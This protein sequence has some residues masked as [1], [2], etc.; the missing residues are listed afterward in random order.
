[1]K[2]IAEFRFSYFFEDRIVFLG[3]N[4]VK[5]QATSLGNSVDEIDID[6]NDLLEK[7]RADTTGQFAQIFSAF[8]ERLR[9]IIRFRLDYRLAPR[10]SDSDVIQECYVRA[11]D[12]LERFLKNPEFPFFVWLRMQA[13]QQVADLHRKHL[14]AEKRDAR[15]E[16]NLNARNQ[17][18]NQTSVQLAAHL[19]AQ[20]TSPSRL[21]QRSEEIVAL[22]NSLNEMNDLDR[23]V[24]ALRHFEELSSNETAQV[25]GIQPAAASKRYVRA[26]KRLQEIMANHGFSG[27]R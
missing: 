13:N 14:Q 22:E 4:S 15:K 23:E 6:E 2:K 24:I 11:A 10:I 25:L 16:I 8:K 26:L 21:I 20:M 1:M 27:E 17:V 5:I 7:L 3:F 18:S 12:R 19:V 9:R